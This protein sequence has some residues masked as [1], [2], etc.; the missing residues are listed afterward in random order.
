M[1]APNKK[2]QKK[3]KVPEEKGGRYCATKR[4]SPPTTGNCWISGIL[5]KVGASLAG[6]LCGKIER[7]G[8]T[9]G[10]DCS[11]ARMVLNV[12]RRKSKVRR[13]LLREEV[14]TKA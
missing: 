14:I 9:E 8:R 12:I 13:R 5:V 7:K 1:G 2:V 10:R 11:G 4:D 6:K 3:E